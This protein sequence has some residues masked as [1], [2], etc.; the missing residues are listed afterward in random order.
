MDVAADAD[1]AGE[2]DDRFIGAD[3]GDVRACAHA[4]WM[5]LGLQRRFDAV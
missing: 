4:G 3:S 5:L 1:G 2:A